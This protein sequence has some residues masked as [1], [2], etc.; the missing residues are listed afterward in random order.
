MKICE[1]SSSWPLRAPLVG[2]RHSRHSQAP[3]ATVKRLPLPVVQRTLPAKKDGF[4]TPKLWIWNVQ[5]IHRNVIW[6]ICFFKAVQH[7]NVIC[8]AC[9]IHDTQCRCL[10]NG[11]HRIDMWIQ[12][13][14]GCSGSKSIAAKD[15]KLRCMNYM[16]NILNLFVLRKIWM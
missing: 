1:D 6:V 9:M 11:W 16:F 3:Y 13:K 4:H 5:S 15:L 2:Q 7:R 12:G 14:R 8:F 10:R